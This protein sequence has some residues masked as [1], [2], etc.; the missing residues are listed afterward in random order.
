MQLV[1]RG[2]GGYQAVVVEADT[3]SCLHPYQTVP[4]QQ[5]DQEVGKPPGVSLRAGSVPLSD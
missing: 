2:S 3:R 5:E 4:T 1:R